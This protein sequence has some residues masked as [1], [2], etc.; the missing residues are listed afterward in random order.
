MSSEFQAEIATLVAKIGEIYDELSTASKGDSEFTIQN[1]QLPEW[2]DEA[3]QLFFGKSSDA[4]DSGQDTETLGL[5]E[6]F[7]KRFELKLNEILGA[8]Q[9]IINDYE[10]LMQRVRLFT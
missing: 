5:L 1:V 3:V 2:D 8:A 9:L 10:E 6:Q 7:N 4:N